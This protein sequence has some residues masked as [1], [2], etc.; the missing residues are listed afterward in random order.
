MKPL[1]HIIFSLIASLILF[2]LNLKPLFNFLFF[3]SAVLIDADH[4]LFYIIR[5]RDLNLMRAYKYFK[6]TRISVYIFHT[7]EFFLLLLIL[8]L[9]FNFFW[10]IFFGCLF[11]MILDL[12]YELFQKDKKYKRVYS[13]VSYLSRKWKR[14]S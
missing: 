4:Y 5:K 14:K 1:F 11:H 8:S 6:K 2:F 9:F 13:L 7:I 10:L 12:I 3:L